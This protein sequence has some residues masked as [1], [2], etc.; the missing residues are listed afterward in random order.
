M[1]YVYEWMCDNVCVCA[2]ARDRERQRQ[3]C[4]E[5]F[6]L[7]KQNNIL[8]TPLEEHLGHAVQYLRKCRMLLRNESD[9]NGD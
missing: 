4:S 6:L 1:F 2:S 5:V 3:R 9:N 8:T 7:T